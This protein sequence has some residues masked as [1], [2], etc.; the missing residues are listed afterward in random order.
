MNSKDHYHYVRFELV[1]SIPDNLTYPEGSVHH[2]STYTAWSSLLE[3]AEHSV[4][5]AVFYWTLTSQDVLNGSQFPSA[6]QGESIFH[7]LMDAG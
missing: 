6:W 2:T 4:D 3:E 5:L 1:E 7:Q